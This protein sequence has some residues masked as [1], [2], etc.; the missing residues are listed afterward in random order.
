MARIELTHVTKRWG[1]F[2]AVDDLN[3]VIEDNAFVTLLGPSGCGKTTTLR[4]IAGLETPTTGRITIDGVTVFDSDAG[5]NVP[6]NKRRVGFLFQNYALWP[7]MTVYQNIAF[8]LGNIKEAGISVSEDGEIIRNEKSTEAPRKLTKA[9]IGRIVERVSKIVKIQPFMDRYPSELSGG[10][11][12]RVAIARTLAPGP[13]V[14]FMDEPLSNLDAKLRLEMRSELQR[15]HLSTG[16]TFVYVTHDQME[17]MTLATRICLIANGVLQQY[18]EPL[19]VY[20]R[21]NNT[22]VADF[23][24]N[25]AVNFIEARETAQ[26]GS[27]T[28]TML[29]GQK[30]RFTPNEPLNT[31][32][33]FDEADREINE[34]ASKQRPVPKANEDKPFNYQIARV[35][36]VSGETA[37]P[38]RE[39]WVIGIRPEFVM[40]TPEGSVEGEIF[41]A[42]P[43]G[44][45]TTVRIRVGNLLLTSVMFGGVTYP[46]G[47]K[48]RLNFTG[49][50]VMLFS[51][52]NGRLAAR[53][54]LEKL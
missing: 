26:D 25:P 5:I 40:I 39:D 31:A 46:I 47:Q 28:L 13:R 34:F 21:P 3:L 12:Q 43:T 35:N 44:M 54:T 33:W 18:D 51:R 23:V 19:T 11:Q 9:E 49:N 42:M 48:I 15:L 24:G 29:E 10:Q 2:Y 45:E 41:S 17:A 52:Q 1:G 22:F 16:S 27:V 53:G 36:D 32:A 4:M 38:G 6:A 14:L 20:D 50:N 8:G 30:F 7:N 37:E